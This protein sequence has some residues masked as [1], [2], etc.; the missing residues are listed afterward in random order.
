MIFIDYGKNLFFYLLFPQYLSQ[1]SLVVTLSP[2]IA[3]EAAL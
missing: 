1:K 2:P 3:V